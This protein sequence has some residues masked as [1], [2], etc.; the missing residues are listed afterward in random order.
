M[1]LY[2]LS[3][4]CFSLKNVNIDQFWEKH[5]F[6]K[7]ANFR[8]KIKPA[9]DSFSLILKKTFPPMIFHEKIIR[10]TL[11]LLT[12]GHF[13]SKIWNFPEIADDH[14]SGTEYAGRMKFV[15][16]CVVLDTLLYS[17][18]NSISTKSVFRL[19][20]KWALHI[21]NYKICLSYL[22][23]V[24]LDCITYVTRPTKSGTRVVC[25]IFNF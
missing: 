23:L 7:F 20:C 19:F 10:F 1:V 16:K 25:D 8:I 9:V 3:Y 5:K 15:S 4:V 12:N 6:W 17:T 22:R 18:N 11:F 13:C 14:N 21:E 2:P 24:L